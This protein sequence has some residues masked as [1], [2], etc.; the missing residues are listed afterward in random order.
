M[1]TSPKVGPV[2]KGSAA[3]TLKY[4]LDPAT[5]GVGTTAMFSLPANAVVLD[6]QVLITT[7]FTGSVTCTVGDGSDADRFLDSASFA[8]QTTGGKTMKQDAQPGSGGHKY[9]A[10]DTVDITIAGATPAAGAAEIYL[11]YLEAEY[12]ES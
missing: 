3:R 8:P 2:Y 12:A 9:T 10:A 6:I 7:A 1:S 11:T 4:T 5:I